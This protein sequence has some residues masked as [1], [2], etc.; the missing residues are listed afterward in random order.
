MSRAI[1]H[2][3]VFANTGNQ[4]EQH[5]SCQTN[6]SENECQAGTQPQTEC[7][8]HSDLENTEKRESNKP[9]EQINRAVKYCSTVKSEETLASIN[10]DRSSDAFTISEPSSNNEYQHL[11]GN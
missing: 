3:G 2:A 5:V 7:T 11:P 6:P 4:K 10:I 8:V 9:A 1:F